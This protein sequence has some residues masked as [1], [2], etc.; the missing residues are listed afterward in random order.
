MIKNKQSKKNYKGLKRKA[1]SKIILS[2]F[3]M[4]TLAFLTLQ[5]FSGGLSNESSY[6]TVSLNGQHLATDTP[7][8]LKDNRVYLS[9]R[10]I[11]DALQLDLAWLPEEN[12]VTLSLKDTTIELFTEDSMRN[13]S[14][15]NGEEFMMDTPLEIVN[16]RTMVPARFVSEKMGFDVDWDGFSFTLL[17]ATEDLA[18]EE[19]FIQSRSYSNEDFLW[20]SRI[21]HVETGGVQIENKLAVANVVLNRMKHP[22]YPSTVYDVIFDRKWAVQFPPAFRAGFGELVPSHESRIASKMALE[23]INNVEGCLWFNN[24]PFTNSNITFYKKIG[25]NYFYY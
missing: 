2:F 19:S 10:S 8:Y 4:F 20:L 5:V 15:I 25:G 18:V 17:L 3:P 1:F 6:I 14:L 7:P 13:M 23:G 12:K 16:D 21:V 24:R 11:C 22:N 9:L